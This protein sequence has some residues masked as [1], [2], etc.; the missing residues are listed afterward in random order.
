MHR[1]FLTKKYNKMF[2]A[3][4]LGWVICTMGELTDTLLSGYFYGEN[5]VAG[6][7]LVIPLINV[8]Y[9]VACCISMGA[10]TIYSIYA[11]EFK[12][13]DMHQTY[14]LAVI[15]SIFFDVIFTILLITGK[16]AFLNFYQPS[17]EVAYFANEYFKSLTLLSTF[18]CTYWVYYYLVREDGDEMAVLYVDIF[19][20]IVGFILSIVL[21][22]TLGVFGVGLGRTISFILSCVFLVRHFFKDSNSLKFSSY[23]GLDKLKEIAEFGSSTAFPMLYT[24]LVAMILNKFII[25]RFGSVY[26]AAFSIQSEI[27]AMYCMFQS[28]AEAAGPMI[29]I[30]YGEHNHVTIKKL[31]KTS[32]KSALI[33]GLLASIAFSL[34][35]NIIPSLFGVT[36]PEIYDTCVY[37]SR[38]MAAFAITYAILFEAIQYY[39]RIGKILL[40]NIIG[41]FYMLIIPLIVSFAL[42]GRLDLTASLSGMQ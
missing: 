21:G 11:G 10:A 29:S 5:A 24:A 32:T 18:Y 39:P 15:V 12:E 16:N 26:L 19:T 37:I 31:V 2:I 41:L 30:A 4:F 9:F 27:V 13:R 42:A 14:G 23:L 38:I 35:A 36:T 34:L 25:D 28:S 22:K 17:P 40:G 8:L 7:Q 33:T 6:V 20:A 1:T 3:G